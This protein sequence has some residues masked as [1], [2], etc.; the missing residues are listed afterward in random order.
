ML[1]TRHR[2]HFENLV[3]IHYVAEKIVDVGKA[4]SHSLHILMPIISPALFTILLP[5][6]IPR[7]CLALFVGATQLT[8][9]YLGGYSRALSH[10]DMSDSCGTETL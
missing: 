7:K 2:K 5:G 10:R 1:T 4:C 6:F 9:P 3:G 8:D